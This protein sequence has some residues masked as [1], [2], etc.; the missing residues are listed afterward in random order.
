MGDHPY[1]STGRFVMTKSYGEYSAARRAG[2]SG[3]D[4]IAVEVFD[5]AYALGASLA[6]ARRERGLK[7]REL[8]ELSG[9]DQGD[10]SRI[11]RGVLAPT[12]PTLLRL[13]EGLNARVTIELLPA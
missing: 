12:T 5:R 4:A 9:V 3:S 1:A 13:A 2:L 10:I 11:E 7:Q 8:A 6:E